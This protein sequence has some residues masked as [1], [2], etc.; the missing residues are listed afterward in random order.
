MH[1]LDY[2]YEEILTPILS[3]IGDNIIL[4]MCE[5]ALLALIWVTLPIWIIPY[6]IIR[7][8]KGKWYEP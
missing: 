1:T 8:K 4:P 2:F 6:L 7:K 3:W 5:Y